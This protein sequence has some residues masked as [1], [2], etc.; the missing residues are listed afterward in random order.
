MVYQRTEY[1][2][3]S[4]SSSRKS[5]FDECKRRYFYNYY[6]SHNGWEEE[7]N[8]E[9]K[10]AYRL[11]KLT[12][13]HLMLG[14]AVHEA[15]EYACKVIT[16]TGKLPEEGELIEIVRNLLN[17]AWVESRDN[18]NEWMTNPGKYKMLHEFYYN[19]KPDKKIIDKIKEKM[20]IVIPNMI[21][22]DSFGEIVKDSCEVKITENMDTF[23]FLETPIYAIPDLVFERFDGKWVVVDWKTGKE[24]DSHL[25]QISVYSM[26]L[27]EKHN[28]S[29]DDIIGKIEYLLTGKSKEVLISSEL[30]ESARENIKESI[31]DMKKALA[32]PDNNIPMQ[33]HE[34]PLAKHKRLCPWCNFY[35]MCKGEMNNG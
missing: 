13:L 22:S 3:W 35:E 5:T 10:Q 12:G 9:S 19:G 18:M 29:E 25:N 17:N 21:N 30:L 23:N 8:E 33:K 28:I 20:E 15:A 11:K 27:R 6:L 7:V 2:V 16:S 24:H 1:P 26:Y 14:S 4:W 32:D 34:Y 31:S